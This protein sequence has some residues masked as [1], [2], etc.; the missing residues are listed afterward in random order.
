MYEAIV[1]GDQ[2]F[3]LDNLADDVVL[4]IVGE[5]Q[6]QGKEGAAAAFYGLTQEGLEEIRLRD[7]I[8]HGNTAAVH[9][10]LMFADGVQVE[11]CDVYKFGSFGKNAKLKAIDSYRIELHS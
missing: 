3:V 5:R 4:N 10:S 8:T 2:R 7:V 11:F 6:L 1:H 9:G